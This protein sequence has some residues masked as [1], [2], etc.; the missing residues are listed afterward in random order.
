MSAYFRRLVLS[1]LVLALAGL[2]VS[3]PARAQDGVPAL[4]V[5]W[6]DVQD[7]G[8]KGYSVVL[9]FNN[10]GTGD[11]ENIYITAV[12]MNGQSPTNLPLPYLVGSVDYGFDSMLTLIF[13]STAGAPGS[14]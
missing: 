13:P 9:H 1:L 8:S 14:S 4:T 7:L 3:S 12:T 5:N 6:S 11:A 10:L 2:A